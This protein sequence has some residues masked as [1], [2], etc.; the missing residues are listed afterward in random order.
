[1]LARRRP[2]RARRTVPLATSEP[3]PMTYGHATVDDALRLAEDSEA[4]TLALFHHAPARTDDEVD[5]IGTRR[6]RSGRRRHRRPRGSDDRS[7]RLTP[8]APDRNGQD[9]KGRNLISHAHPGRHRRR[10]LSRTRRRH[11]PPRS[12]T[13]GRGR[14]AGAAT[15]TRCWRWSST[16]S[17][18]S[19][20]PT[21]ACR[22]AAPTKACVRP[23]CCVISIRRSAS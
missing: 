11:P 18:T 1:M 22:R 7:R 13:R 10:Q 16:R 8:D 15:S 4:R 21:S 14:R 3:S 20:S 12:P 5:A 9:A 6:G 17:P 23:T 2:P 19:C